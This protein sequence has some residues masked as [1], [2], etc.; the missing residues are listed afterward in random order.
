LAYTYTVVAE[1]HT[2]SNDENQR[3]R[4]ELT[5]VR[6]ERDALREALEE[7]RREVERLKARLGQNSSNS[8]WPSS[9]DL[10]G[11]TPKPSKPKREPTGRKRGGQKGHKGSA[12]ALL[13]VEQ[14]SAV[15]PCLPM[16]CAGCGLALCGEDPNP[17]RH[18]VAEIPKVVAHV[19]EYRL[20]ALGCA[21][22]GATTR[23]QLPDGVPYG[24]FGPRLQSLA[25][26]LSSV[27]RLS[28]RNVRRLMLDYLGVD[29]SL[30]G[31]SNLEKAMSNALRHPVEEARAAVREQPVAHADETGWREAGQKA[32]LWTVVTGI[33]I[34]FTV[35]LSRGA[36]VAKEM[37]GSEFAGRLV[38]DRWGG[39]GWVPLDRRQLCWAHLIRDFQKL[40]D[41]G[42]ATAPLGR[43]LGDCARDLFH[44]WREVRGGT[45]DIEALRTHVNAEIAPTIRRLLAEG[46]ALPKG[47]PRRGMCAALLKV[48][49]AMWTFLNVEGVEP[50]NNLAERTIRHGVLWRKT[51]FGTQSVAGSQFVER[52]LTTVATLRL[53][54]RNVLDYLT[55]ACDAANRRLPAPSL[56]PAD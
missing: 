29:V 24:P 1:I 50:T 52:M 42:G 55:E 8:H 32:W 13:P 3:L 46:A 35:R 17:E 20:H 10:P 28:K 38:S 19:T 5:V 22:C 56:L 43:E 18:Q 37:L 54:R 49:P 6:A 34:V 2:G 4:D 53:Q 23:A 48:E 33:A 16:A 7:L 15:V 39:Y 12:R 45:C 27:Y 21:G 31:V 44:R 26:M 9:T 25:V 36:A 41:S 30:G 40:A 51:S 14:V 11:K 47:T